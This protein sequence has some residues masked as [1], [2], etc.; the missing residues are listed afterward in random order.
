MRLHHFA[1]AASLA[2]LVGCSSDS[3]PPPVTTRPVVAAPAPTPTPYDGSYAGTLTRRAGTQAACGP[4]ASRATMTVANG[5]A[6]LAYGRGGSMA[7]NGMVQGDG[8]LS[9]ASDAGAQGSGRI[10]RARA[11]GTL[12]SG[13]CSYSMALTKAAQRPAA[14]A[15]AR[16][17]AAAAR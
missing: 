13:D 4:T 6:T 7:A 10:Q 14:R 1:L 2:A 12:R 16:P 9:L 17:A 3:T 15:A 8:S 11:T 5:R